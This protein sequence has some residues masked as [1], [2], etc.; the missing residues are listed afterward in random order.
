LIRRYEELDEVVRRYVRMY[1]A[2]LDY[3]SALVRFARLWAY[4]RKCIRIS[5]T[6]GSRMCRPTSSW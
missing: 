1:V 6:T 2:P 4:A 5:L 3:R